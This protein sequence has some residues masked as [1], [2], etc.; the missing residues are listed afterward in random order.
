MSFNPALLAGSRSFWDFFL[1]VCAHNRH[2]NNLSLPCSSEDTF[3]L[4][5]NTPPPFLFCYAKL[6]ELWMREQVL[7]GQQRLHSDTEQLLSPFVRH[8]FS[9]LV[10]ATTHVPN[11]SFLVQLRAD[12]LGAVHTPDTPP[13]KCLLRSLALAPGFSAWAIRGLHLYPTSVNP[14]THKINIQTHSRW[15]TLAVIRAGLSCQE[16]LAMFKHF[17]Q[18][19]CIVLFL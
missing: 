12:W 11:H 14:Y 8:P 16:G 9:S 10:V 5:K 18:H 15:S 7:V 6:T 17:S 13:M 1:C 3:Q 4:K 2:E 19:L